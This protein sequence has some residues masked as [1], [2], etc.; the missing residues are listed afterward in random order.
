MTKSLLNLL[1]LLLVVIPAFSFVSPTAC[2]K[3]TPSF[4]SPLKM[5]STTATGPNI[6]VVSQP[7]DEF[8]KKKGVFDWGTWGCEVS[9]F[10]WT[11]DSSESCYL[12]EGQVTV[13]PDGRP[14]L[15]EKVIL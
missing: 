3:S 6:E 13:T 15:L 4:A 11:Y 8:L 9:K 2:G 7:D 1:L 5:S 12:L 10:P 14:P